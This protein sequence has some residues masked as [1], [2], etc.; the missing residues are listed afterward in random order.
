[1]DPMT[2]VALV[3]GV[4]VGTVGAIA[5]GRFYGNSITGKAKRDAA[6]TVSDAER[7]AAQIV[8]DAKTD[9]KELEVDLRRKME[10]EARIL[11][12]EE[13]IDKRAE[14]LDKKAGELNGQERDLV[15]REKQVDK[16]RE[17]LEVLKQEQTRK[18][19][20]ISGLTAEQA[21]KEIFT[22]LENDVKRDAAF[23]LKRIEDELKEEA[24]KKAKWIISEAIQRCA[25]DHVAETT[26]SVVNLPT[27]EMKGRIIGREGRNIRALEN[28]TG[29]SVIID[30]TPEAVI[31]SGFDPVR[32]EVA[33]ITLER[34]IEDGRIHPARIEEMTEKVSEEMA[35]TIKER[36][37]QAALEADV[38]GLHP[39]IMKLMGRLSYRTS[40]GQNV[41]RHSIEVANLCAVM[42]AELGVN[43]QEAKRAGFIHDMG[44][45]LT[46]EVEGTHA[47]LGHD[48][49]KRHGESDVVANAIGAHH[50]EMPMNTV[51]AALVQAADAM[52]ASR[53]GARSEQVSNYIKRLEQLEDICH[54]FTGVTQAYAIQ[55]GREVRVVVEPTSVNDAEAQM[56][57]RDIAK[58]IETD[59]TYPGQ[60]RVTVVRETRAVELAK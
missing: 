50:N 31:L 40:Y 13:N 5:Y 34:L 14:T 26:V 23:E 9:V 28:A 37:E 35:R 16:D 52:S 18:L 27:D 33:R 12:K 51:I 54:D 8:R 47:V 41:L 45:A 49:A 42:A 24:D 39:E 25:S 30:D 22:T 20:E 36:G 55:A 17:N 58:K 60:I 43:V 11:Q 6:Q 4:V 2:L 29:I 57:A 7:E 38:H 21:R 44:K 46:H 48:I 15:K 59:M 56:L 10:Q 32:R 53:P 19:E 3:A 1:M